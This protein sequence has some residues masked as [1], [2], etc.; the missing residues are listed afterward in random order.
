GNEQIAKIYDLADIY[1]SDNIDRVSDDFITECGITEGSFD[2]IS[3]CEYAVPSHWDIGKVYKRLILAVA[4]NKGCGIVE[5][6]M[7]VFGSPI[8]DLIEDYNSSFYYDNPSAIFA[9]Y[10]NNCIPE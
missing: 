9:T 8:V 5:A 3:S 1:H 6:L 4:E 10:Q 7:D 2:N